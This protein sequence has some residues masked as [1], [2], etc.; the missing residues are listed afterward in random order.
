MGQGKYQAIEN[1]SWYGD[2]FNSAFLQ[3]I[4]ATE[5]QLSIGRISMV[6]EFNIFHVSLVFF[7]P[8]YWYFLYSHTRLI[9]SSCEKKVL[10]KFQVVL[11]SLLQ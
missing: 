5:I 8:P 4:L 10:S 7:F 1:D 6:H 9:T 2:T 11:S 3:C